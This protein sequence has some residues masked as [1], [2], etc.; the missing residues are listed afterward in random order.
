MT[1]L[2][3]S[4]LPFGLGFGDDSLQM[5]SLDHVMWFHRPFRADGWLL[6]DQTARST[7]AARGLSSGSIFTRDGELAVS[8]AQEGLVRHDR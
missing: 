2:D 3:T 4:I 7:E 6:Y 8:V 1:L 5:A